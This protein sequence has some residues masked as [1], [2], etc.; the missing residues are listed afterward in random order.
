MEE[1][2]KSLDV[3][4]GLNFKGKVN[5]DRY[6]KINPEINQFKNINI[7]VHKIP[8]FILADALYLPFRNF[9]FKIIYC[10]HV[11]EHVK[12]PN[13]LIQELKRIC[14]KNG[15]INI[16]CPHRFSKNA[17]MPYHKHYFT[18]TWFN[19]KFK[20]NIFH[21]DISLTYWYPIPFVGFRLKDE[22]TI[23]IK[24]KGAGRFAKRS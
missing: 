6:K 24:R 1:N 3:G 16:K 23:R 18:I 11:I 9:S 17:K 13:K 12:N 19:K 7:N 14:T 15:I 21:V 8:N 10:Y 22:I 2:F 20:K 4:C 5:L